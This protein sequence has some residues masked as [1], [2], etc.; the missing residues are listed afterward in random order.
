MSELSRLPR[1]VQIARLRTLA[2]R[3]LALYGLEGASPSLLSLSQFFNTSFGVTGTDGSRYVLRIHRPSTHP[4]RKRIKIESELWWLNCVREDLSLA[5]PTPVR[6]ET[7]EYAV[8]VDAPGVPEPR[9]CVLF[10][11]MEGRFLARGLRPRHLEQVGM[12]TARLHDHSE[13]LTVPLWFTRNVIDRADPD[14]E[15]SATKLFAGEWSL[16]AAGVLGAVIRRA[17]AV[18]ERL[19]DGPAV[20]GVI[21]ADIHHWNYLFHQGRIRL[22]DFDDSGWGHYLYDLAVTLQQVNR[23]PQAPTLRQALLAGYRRLRDLSPEHEAMIDTFRM[24]REAQDATFVLRGRD[25]PS[26]ARLLP[27]IEP[28]LKEMERFLHAG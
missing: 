16:E 22:I 18:Q 21:H 23:L 1:R 4:E 7:G 2:E 24:L 26:Q 17:R 28:A 19:G 25:D 6:A 13:R 11:W 15:E 27:T 5:V 8:H 14:F 12:L 3:A 10:H 20:Y 9:F